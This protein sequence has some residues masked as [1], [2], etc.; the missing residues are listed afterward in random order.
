[1]AAKRALRRGIEFGD[2]TFVV[3]RHDA[4]ERR[5]QDGCLA[6]LAASQFLLGPLAFVNID[7]EVVPADDM[8]VRIP[9]R[10]STGLKP[11]IG[12]IEAPSA[13][14]DVGPLV[15]AL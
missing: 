8:S 2:A 5:V 13:Y 12:A 14:F 6:C 10:K 7:Q 3:D 11:A 1:M 9:E 4:V 15:P